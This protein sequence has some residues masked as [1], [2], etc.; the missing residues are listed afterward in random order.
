MDWPTTPLGQV[1]RSLEAADGAPGPNHPPGPLAMILWQIVGYPAE[2]ARQARGWAALVETVG[3]TPAEI[4]AASDAE[5]E[6][7]CR[8]GG[9]IATALRAERLRFT[10]QRVVDRFDGDL[11]RVLALPTAAAR[12]E[13]M[14][15]PQIGAP[16]ADRI[17]L[18]SAAASLLAPES[19]ALRVLI[20]L[21]FLNAEDGYSKLYRAAN[22]LAAEQLPADV[23]LMQTAHLLLR[24]HGLSACKRGGLDH[25]ACP[26]ASRCQDR[27]TPNG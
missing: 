18:F 8:A 10:A 11:T 7:V 24:R 27:G 9:G 16:G 20:R 15:F 21:G 13:L 3:T 17:L 12:K 25:S 19:N 22:A 1:L 26:L 23:G 14:A 5:L 4:L 6:A 2:D